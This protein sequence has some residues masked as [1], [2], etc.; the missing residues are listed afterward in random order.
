MGKKGKERK[1]KRLLEEVLGN[2]L[3]S[4]S[5]G[6]DEKDSDEEFDSSK[7]GKEK[8]GNVH[9]FIEILHL[10]TRNKDLYHTKRLKAFRKSIFPLLSAQRHKF[11]E[12]DPLEEAYMDEQEIHRVLS[13]QNLATSIRCADYFSRNME[14]FHAPSNKALRKALHPIVNLHFLPDTNLTSSLSSRKDRDEQ[15]SN[16]IHRAFRLRNWTDALEGLRKLAMSSEIPKLGALQRWVRECNVAYED[17]NCTGD[18]YSSIYLSLLDAVM[19]CMVRRQTASCTETTPSS[20]NR[21]RQEEPVKE[22]RSSEI[23]KCPIFAVSSSSCYSSSSSSSCLPQTFSPSNTWSFD[24][25]AFISTV[26]IVRVIPGEE[27]LNSKYDLNIFASSIDSFPF[28]RNATQISNS[29]EHNSVSPTRYDVPGVPGAFVLC[30]ILTEKECDYL[31]SAAEALKFTP[32]VVEG[33]DNLTMIADQHL[34]DVIYSRS[35]ELMPPSIGGC[36]LSGINARFRFFRY[37][38]SAVYRPHIDGSWPGSAIDCNGKL[39]DDF[40]KDRV[41]KLTF[42]IYLNSNFTGGAT[43]FFVPNSSKIG[44]IEARGVEPTRGCILCFPHGDSEY[45]LVHEGS[46]VVSG[47]KYVIRTDVLYKSSK[48][49]RVES[50]TSHDASS[51]EPEEDFTEKK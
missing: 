42:L 2:E 33:I 31:V 41:S 6:D 28:D 20:H 36:S 50:L 4:G 21:Q 9:I 25:S 35:N 40:Y 22:V 5:E 29:D 46:A 48:S 32:D 51:Q 16:S 8:V 1:K 37:F 11:F 44:I 43:T 26:K 17:T 30:N 47:T 18:N 38:A 10:L 3:V 27:R 23:V 15:I 34:V 14:S 45:S 24:A 13:F 19:R 49:V 12:A 7:T 39:V